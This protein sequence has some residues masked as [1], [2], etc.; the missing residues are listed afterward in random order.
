M[1]LELMFKGLNYTISQATKLLQSDDED[2]VCSRVL[3]LIIYHTRA[4][5]GVK[6]KRRYKT[7]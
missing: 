1:W 4:L 7:N 3:A 2:I 5:H 6:G